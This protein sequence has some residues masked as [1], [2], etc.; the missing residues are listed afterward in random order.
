MAFIRR[1]QDA[2]IDT[3]TA[4]RMAEAF[5]AEVCIAIDEALEG[6]RAKNRRRQAEFRARQAAEHNV[7]NVTREGVTLDNVIERD[8]TREPARV[9]DKTPKL[10]TTG[11]TGGDGGEA[12]ERASDDWPQGKAK[13]HAELLVAAVNSPRLDPSKSPGLVTTMG[14]LE[15]WRRD[16]ASWEHDVL[17]V[18]T[19]LCAKQRSPVSTWKFFDNAIAR[20]IAD[21]RAA[22][23]IPEA[24]RVRATG[25]PSLT[26]RISA[27]AAEARR[28][29][30]ES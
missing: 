30:L 3:E 6:Q 18:V 1:C 20:S 23:D 17:P 24:G 16:G 15:A 29:V 9:R 2:G 5:E 25:P 11:Y 4:L 12:R 7:N 27:E 19:A 28:R 14:R 22:L 26:E 10:V 8:T 13:N 21:N